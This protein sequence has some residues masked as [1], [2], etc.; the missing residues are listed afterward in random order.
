MPFRRISSKSALT[1]LSAVLTN[2]AMNATHFGGQMS[3]KYRRDKE[4]HPH[5]SFISNKSHSTS[6]VIVIQANVRRR[7]ALLFYF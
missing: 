3:L 4:V 5:L 7:T 1:H 6:L 2:R